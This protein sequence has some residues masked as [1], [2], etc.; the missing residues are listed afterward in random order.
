MVGAVG[1]KLHAELMNEGWHIFNS[2]F[3]IFRPKGLKL[4]DDDSPQIKII[5]TA[6]PF[7]AQEISSSDSFETRSL[8]LTVDA[9][10]KTSFLGGLNQ[11]TKTD[12]QSVDS[13]KKEK[14]YY[15]NRRQNDCY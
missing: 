5:E 1:R 10:V 9:S 14:H 12:F 6:K 4:W 11:Q 13:L 7:S 2:S 8:L 15:V 3:Y